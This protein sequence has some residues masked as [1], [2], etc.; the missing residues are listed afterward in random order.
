MP[1]VFIN[2]DL[3]DNIQKSLDSTLSYRVKNAD[4]AVDGANEKKLVPW[5]KASNEA[6]ARG[7]KAPPMPEL[8]DGK[9]RFLRRARSGSWYFPIGL[10]PKVLKLLQW[11][12]VEI[13]QDIQFAET[14]LEGGFAWN[15][16]ELRDYQFETLMKA[17]ACRGGVV[18]LPTGSGKTMIALKLIHSIQRPTI[19]L[20]HRKELFDQ[21]A[22]QIKKYLGLVPVQY[23]DAIVGF[24][25][26]IDDNKEHPMVV[27]A[28]IPTLAMASR[29]KNAVALTILEAKY[30]LL[31]LDEAHHTPADT[32]Y[33]V[34]SKIDALYKYGFSA[35]TER[36]DGEDMKMDA[37]LGPICV[38]MNAE[39]LIEKGFLA[40][41]VF[42]FIEVPAS[43]AGR[44]FA[45][46]YKTGI[47]QNEGR[48]KAIAARVKQLVDEGRQ[49]YVHVEHIAHGRI[50]SQLLGIPFVY[51][52]SKDRD[53]TIGTFRKGFTRALVSTLLG[54]GVD[55]PT[56]SAIV[57]AGGR[58]TEVGTIQKVGRALR[59]TA[60]VD[61]AVV[62]DFA[63]RGKWLGDHSLARYNAYCKV[64][65]EDIVRGVR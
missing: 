22:E 38:K 8:W 5:R 64:Y 9:V 16:P 46:I 35:T 4:F 39:S 43:G 57:M 2:G 47:V 13:T 30:D 6:L 27:L 49:V 19:V 61:T 40:R 3:P 42:E 54:E 48:N 26:P 34:A 17:I 10:L 50:L 37:A 45:Q 31:I 36:E 32:F 11:Y 7:E 63:D 29:N 60:G 56:I 33:S 52:K 41:P 24:V 58:K 12:D 20:V 44:T 55:I 1:F 21:W 59:P 18:S 15:G 14:S 53:E 25:S 28:M 62:V 51:S 65:G 23:T